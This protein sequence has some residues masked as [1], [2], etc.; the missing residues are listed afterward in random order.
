MPLHYLVY[1]SKVTTLFTDPELAGLLVK[2]R[3]RNEALG[4][5]G[6]LLYTQDGR[7]VQVLEGEA[8][9][10]HTLYHEQIAHDTRHQYLQ[11]L[12]DGPLDYRRFADWRMGYCLATPE[13]LAELTGYC[14]TADASFLLPMLP[15]LSGK[16]LDKLLDYVQHTAASA[17]LKEAPRY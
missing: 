5:T 17:G 1:E 6:L 4:L 13:D 10:I 16:L 3:Q 8:E 15:T 12:A 2:A 7:F 11:V 14:S 9:A